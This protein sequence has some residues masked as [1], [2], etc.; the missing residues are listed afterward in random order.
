MDGNRCALQSPR[1]PSAF[2]EKAD[3]GL[4]GQD[5]ERIF[6][7]GY[8]QGKADFCRQLPDSFV[9]GIRS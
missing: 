3:S 8:G 7:R 5:E 9:Q 6:G 1:H 2:I 4:D